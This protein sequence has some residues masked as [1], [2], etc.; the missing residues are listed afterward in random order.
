MGVDGVDGE[1]KS[2][3]MFLLTVTSKL[4]NGYNRLL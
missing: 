2:S 3:L 4:L 1:V